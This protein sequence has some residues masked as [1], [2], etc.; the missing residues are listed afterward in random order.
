MA[1]VRYSPGTDITADNDYWITVVPQ[2]VY[3]F[4]IR[5]VLGTGTFTVQDG[6]SYDQAEPD[7]VSNFTLPTDPT[8]DMAIAATGTAKG[9]DVRCNGNRLVFSLAS[10][11][12]LTARIDVGKVP[13]GR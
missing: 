13:H 12:G 7:E 2:T 6:R 10:A 3:S 1:Y 9:Y 4:T 11:S 8:A 5:Y